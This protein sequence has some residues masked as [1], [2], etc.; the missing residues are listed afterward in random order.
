MPFKQQRGRHMNIESNIMADHDADEQIAEATATTM[1]VEGK[2]NIFLQMDI[3]NR[4]FD[5]LCALLRSGDITKIKQDTWDLLADHL[6]GKIK[7]RTGRKQDVLTELFANEPAYIEYK[8][9]CKNGCTK[10]E[11]IAEMAERMASREGGEGTDYEG[12]I[13]GRIEAFMAKRKKR[14]EAT[15]TETSNQNNK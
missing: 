10:D 2:L 11:A 12:V 13:R 15:T 9:L 4:D 5:D 6:E 3:M 7:H 1:S 8:V 14:R